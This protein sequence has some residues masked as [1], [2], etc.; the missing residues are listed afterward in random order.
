[1][2]DL[3]FSIGLFS[4][5]VS[6]LLKDTDAFMSFGGFFAV[7]FCAYKLLTVTVYESKDTIIIKRLLRQDKEYS[8]ADCHFPNAVSGWRKLFMPL[9]TVVCNGEPF[10]FHSK[11]LNFL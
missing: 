5:V 9:D 2:P 8:K 11:W 7:A 6:A 3:V 4:I 1:L 10:L